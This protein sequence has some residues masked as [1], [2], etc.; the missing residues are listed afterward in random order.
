MSAADKQ[1]EP[2]PKLIGAARKQG[3]EVVMLGL[4]GP[5]G[6]CEHPSVT[7]GPAWE[8]ALAAVADHVAA[9]GSRRG[10]YDVA[11]KVLREQAPPRGRGF[12]TLFAMAIMQH[13]EA[14]EWRT[15]A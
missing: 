10:A 5:N 13:A 7:L 14:E 1:P 4:V 11:E 15:R 9:T 3:S 12:L 6:T 2:S 8:A